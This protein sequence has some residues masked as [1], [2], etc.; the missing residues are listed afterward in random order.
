MFVGHLAVV[1]RTPV[2]ALLD[3]QLQPTA[4][5]QDV[6]FEAEKLT[7]WDSSILTFLLQLSELCRQ[8][9]IVVERKDLRPR[10][11]AFG[12]RRSGA[13][14]GARREAIEA[15]FLERIGIVSIGL[16]GSAKEMLAF[17][18]DMTVT[19]IALLRLKAHYRASDLFLLIQQC[20]RKF[21][22]LI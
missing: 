14:K 3:R 22:L 20:G 6:V 17:L 19:F 5:V 9:A 16:A 7:S 18:G 2:A 13:R 15:S 10:A 21:M 12:S 1:R 4:R 8:R 11:S